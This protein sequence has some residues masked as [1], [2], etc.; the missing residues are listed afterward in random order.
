MLRECG[1]TARGGEGGERVRGA[2][3]ERLSQ[4]MSGK[5]EKTN[6][7]RRRGSGK[8]AEKTCQGKEKRKIRKKGVIWLFWGEVV[9][10]GDGEAR[11]A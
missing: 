10:S 7:R 2:E 3:R 9:V 8:K 11:R 5:N 6:R 1:Y 4:I